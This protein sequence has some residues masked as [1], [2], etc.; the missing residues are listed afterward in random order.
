MKEESEIEVSFREL[1]YDI[2]RAAKLAIYK[3]KLN[4]QPSEKWL[5]QHP[6]VDSKYLPIDKEEWLFDSIFQEWSIEI[7]REGQ[8]MNSV[9]IVIRLHYMNPVTGEWNSHDGIGAQPLQIDS[10]SKFS[11]DTLKP[12]AFQMALP[13]AKSYAIKD[14]ADHLG[15]LFGRD[16]NRKATVEYQSAYTEKK[17]AY[18]TDQSASR[19]LRVI[20]GCKTKVEL[21]K[22]FKFCD[23]IESKQAY[24]TKFKELSNGVGL[25]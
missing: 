18:P 8:M 10:K 7:I 3:A 25:L 21:E 16:V 1:H 5:K 2:D 11:M 12:A 20:S 6:I 19:I 22:N 23:S 15:K 9:Y 14:A 13:M 17:P 24:D 4:K